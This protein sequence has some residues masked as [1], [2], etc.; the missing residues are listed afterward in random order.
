MTAPTSLLDFVLNLLKDPQARHEFRE[1]PGHVLAVNGL[2]DVSAA[3]IHETLPLVTDNRSVELIGNGHLAPPPVE[4][5]P[6]ES[7]TSAA[8]DYLRH[9]TDIYTYDVHADEP[10]HVN[11]WAVDDGTQAFD[12][13][14]SSPAGADP[15]ASGTGGADGGH[16][17][18]SGQGGTSG[19]SRGFIYGDHTNGQIYGDHVNG[20][21]Y[22]D[23]V[24]GGSQGAAGTAD[25]PVVRSPAGDEHQFG[26][27]QSN[28]GLH[29]FGSGAPGG[30]QGDPGPGAGDTGPWHSNPGTGDA[31]DHAGS[32]TAGPNDSGYLH[33][34]PSA[35]GDSYGHQG[36]EHDFYDDH[37]YDGMHLDLH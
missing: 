12:D 16:W 10:A 27:G 6:G 33:D 13:P 14:P 31:P 22:G 19:P 17:D 35:L 36:G 1:N 21:I 30:G 29:S 18:G 9:I 15:I 8:I 23:H 26:H 28:G 7:G 11:I 37:G 2:S 4:P 25:A 20:Q 3:D 34:P 5:V 24:S 32:G